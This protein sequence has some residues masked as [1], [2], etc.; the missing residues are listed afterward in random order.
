MRSIRPVAQSV[1]PRGRRSMPKFG[2]PVGVR[3][4]SSRS[5]IYKHGIIQVNPRLQAMVEMIKSVENKIYHNEATAIKAKSLM[6]AVGIILQEIPAL[7]KAADEKCDG[8]KYL[9][10][11]PGKEGRGCGKCWATNKA[12]ELLGVLNPP[13]RRHVPFS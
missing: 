4:I 13:G 12:S 6:N 7:L 1:V 11:D 10:F 5:A 2:P 8:Y 3:R 9:L